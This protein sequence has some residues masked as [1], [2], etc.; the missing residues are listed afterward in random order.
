MYPIGM[1]HI[2]IYKLYFPFIGYQ[3]FFLKRKG[4]KQVFGWPPNTQNIY[5]STLRQKLKYL[6]LIRQT[7]TIKKKKIA[8]GLKLE[9]FRL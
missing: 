4:K 5:A 1:N 3:F 7:Y 8:A 2:S 9:T 6:R